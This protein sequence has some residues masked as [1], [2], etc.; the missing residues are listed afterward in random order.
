[1]AALVVL[2]NAALEVLRKGEGLLCDAGYLV[3]AVSSFE[4]AKAIIDSVSPSVLVTDI[5]LGAF[6]GLHLAIHSRF[7]HPRLPII[8]TYDRADPLFELDARSCG[9]ALVTA[10]LDSPE[11]LSRVQSSVRESQS[12]DPSGLVL[13]NSYSSSSTFF[14]IARSRG[15]GTGLRR[16]RGRA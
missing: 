16:S 7:E 1:M 10:P 9:A 11:F 2:V 8:V 12:S 14:E 6:N 5:R 15:A 13:A 3:A 4:K